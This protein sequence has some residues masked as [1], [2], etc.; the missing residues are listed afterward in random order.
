MAGPK[1]LDR[2]IQRLLS[3]AQDRDAG[4]GIDRLIGHFI[5]EEMQEAV[6]LRKM[7]SNMDICGSHGWL[8][9]QAKAT[10]TRAGMA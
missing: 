3:I 6:A 5:S 10:T 4:K 7:C 1:R 2:D 8:A 9:S